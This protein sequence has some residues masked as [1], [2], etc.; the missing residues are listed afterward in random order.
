MLEGKYAQLI[1][2]VSF[3]LYLF[4]V[5]V[6]YLLWAYTDTLVWPKTHA[7]EAGFL[8][9]LFSLVLTLPIAWASE[10]WIERWSVALGRRL[11]RAIV[12]KF[13]RQ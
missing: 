4:N 12:A 7:L 13:V 2:R 11:D 8:I 3:S 6:L 10:H 9:G 1:G 5:P